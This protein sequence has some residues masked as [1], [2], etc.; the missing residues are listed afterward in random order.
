MKVSVLA[1]VLQVFHTVEMTRPGNANKKTSFLSGSEDRGLLNA[2]TRYWN[3]TMWCQ[4]ES[5][6]RCCDLVCFALM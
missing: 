5:Q 6:A 1:I 2:K 4:N 3:Y